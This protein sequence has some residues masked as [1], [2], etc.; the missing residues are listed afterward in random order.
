MTP[1]TAEAGGFVS[2]IG[3]IRLHADPPL[4]GQPAPPEVASFK[5]TDAAAHAMVELRDPPAN[6]RL[7]WEW[8]ALALLDGTRDR[9]LFEKTLLTEPGQAFMASSI[10]FTGLSP[11]GIYC[12]DVYLENT[13]IHRRQF[14]IQE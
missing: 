7:R 5:P 13:L 6:E 11:K 3:P 4:D 14:R 12:V 1:P 8:H 9:K 10:Q 2:G